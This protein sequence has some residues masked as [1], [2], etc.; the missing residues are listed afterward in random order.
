MFSKR[1]CILIILLFA[2]LIGFT[3]ET[4][5]P[6]F[7]GGIKANRDKQ[8]NNLVNNTI[9]K[10]LSFPLSDSTEDK[11]QAA[12]DASGFIKYKDPFLADCIQTT[13]SKW[14]NLSDD[15][16]I[17]TL[18]LINGAYPS[19]FSTEIYATLNSSNAKI[20]AI[21]S[22]YLL[23][24]DSNH[25]YKN[26]IKNQLNKVDSSASDSTILLCLKEELNNNSTFLS[27]EELKQLL[28]P[29]FLKNNIV[30]YSF[31]RKNRDRIGMAVIRNKSGNFITDS[32]GS[33]FSVPQFARSISNLPYFI[34]RGN[35]P[36]GIFKMKGR[37]VS[38]SYN[39]GPTPNIQLAM[40]FESK[41][42]MFLG[43]STIKDSIWTEKL[44][45]SLLPENLKNKFTLYQSFYA[46][47]LGRTEIIAHGTT[48]N[49]EYYKGESY[50]PHT[51]SEGCLS[52][53]ERWSEE[54]GKRIFSNQQ[55]L[56]DIFG[57]LGGAIGYCF[58]IELNDKETD[59]TLDE[60]LSL[61]N[62]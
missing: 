33:I 41:I 62:E 17:S 26:E 44:Y 58:V 56:A 11:W 30:L 7:K 36:Q 50:Y 22:A 54:N 60:I 61:L 20:F 18:E 12:F 2:Y 37:A 51:P 59:V 32:T 47:K 1:N 55:K 42:Q 8:Y 39:I 31:Q 25:L 5:V 9:R 28:S 3:Q 19:I 14:N 57:N 13:F 29:S 27:K 24:S 53:V 43:D 45:A 48:V 6:F 15:F 52:T 46:G 4:I 34:S 10:N 35:T 23:N 40:P 49:P 16:K 38:K 21:S